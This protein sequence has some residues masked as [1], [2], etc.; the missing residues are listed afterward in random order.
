MSRKVNRNKFVFTGKCNACK[1][2][3][4]IDVRESKYFS[5]EDT[6][7]YCSPCPEC[8]SEDVDGSWGEPAIVLLNGLS[9]YYYGEKP[10]SYYHFD[11][12]NTELNAKLQNCATLIHWPIKKEREREA[13]ERF[14]ELVEICNRLLK[15]RE[16]RNVGKTNGDDNNRSR[17]NLESKAD[18]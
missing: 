6:N 15:E 5:K 16:G 11:L 1:T 8:N 7:N 10:G 4:V 14:P 13:I 17:E 18:D 2:T 9:F 12:D 3:F